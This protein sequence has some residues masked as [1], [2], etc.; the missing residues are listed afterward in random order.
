MLDSSWSPYTDA[1][2]ASKH[3]V[4]GIIG[5]F[6]GGR[7]GILAVSGDIDPTSEEIEALFKRFENP[8]SGQK[9]IVGGL[10]FMATNCNSEVLT[11]RNGAKG[12]VVAISHKTIVIGISGEGQ[13]QGICLNI[14]NNIVSN[15]KSSNY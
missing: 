1:I 8:A 2:I 12:I 10:K 4:A 13:N 11:G 3:A 14:V 5:F 15:L 7:Y 9:L 6:I